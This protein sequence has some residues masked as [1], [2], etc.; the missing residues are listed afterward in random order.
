V[1]KE[2]PEYT[3]VK[4][5]ALK[6][7]VSGDYYLKSTDRWYAVAVNSETKECIVL[8]WYCG[9]IKRRSIDAALQMSLD[10]WKQ[11]INPELGVDCANYL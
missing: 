3:E 5:V 8:G 10:L 11:L 9:E 7:G 2:S 1:G 4:A 6:T